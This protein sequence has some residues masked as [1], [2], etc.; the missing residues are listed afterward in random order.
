MQWD[1]V[2]E[3]GTAVSCRWTD[4]QTIGKPPKAL[5]N[6]PRDTFRSLLNVQVR[7]QWRGA[8]GM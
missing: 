5:F 3:I 4:Q 2:E 8:V 7:V 6:E 1:R